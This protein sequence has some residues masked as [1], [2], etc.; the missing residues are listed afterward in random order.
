[1]VTRGVDMGLRL[2]LAAGFGILLEDGKRTDYSW[3]DVKKVLEED[4]RR[5]LRISIRTW[6]KS[7]VESKDHPV[8]FD[9]WLRGDGFEKLARHDLSIW[10]S[11]RG[12]I[13]AASWADD[14]IEKNQYLIHD[15]IRDTFAIPN[16]EYGTKSFF[17]YIYDARHDDYIDYAL[18][19][20]LKITGMESFEI[21]LPVD[22]N[23]KGTIIEKKT[24]DERKVYL[25]NGTANILH[26][27]LKETVAKNKE[28]PPFFTSKG[29][30]KKYNDLKLKE[31]VYTDSVLYDQGLQR[32]KLFYPE[33]TLKNIEKYIVGWW[34]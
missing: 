34:S 17:G 25:P 33:I 1:M 19:Y 28:N 27:Y 9:E 12:E 8:S 26:G 4:A 7:W 2:N 3:D 30:C 23:C 18:L 13:P 14:I 6:R 20:T 31:S 29:E 32:V 24:I 5:R 15:I 10:T 21:H 22:G 16:E 11:F